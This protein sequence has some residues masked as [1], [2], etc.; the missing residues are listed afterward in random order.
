MSPLRG[1]DAL[2]KETTMSKLIFAPF[3]KGSTLQKKKKNWQVR[4]FSVDLFFFKKKAS[5]RIRK[6]TESHKS[7]LPCQNIIAFL[8]KRVLL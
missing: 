7:R 4:S 3:C 5:W 2:S 6:Q 8:L 1:T